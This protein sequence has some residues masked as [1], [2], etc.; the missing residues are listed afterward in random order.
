MPRKKKIFLI[1]AIFLAALIQSTFLDYLR[2]QGIKPDILL[3]LVIF[4]GLEADK[5]FGL[6]AGLFA[7]L[8]KDLLSAGPLG[9]N[10]L[11]FGLTGFILGAYTFKLYRERFVLKLVICFAAAFLISHF[12]YLTLKAYALPRP[13]IESLMMIIIPASLYTCFAFYIISSTFSKILK[14]G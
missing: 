13:Y 9:L 2:I 10:T 5:S 6:K 4:I 7:G 12:Y 14:V 11:A 3:V 8:L 1:F